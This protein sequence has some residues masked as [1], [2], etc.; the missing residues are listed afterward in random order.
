M[1]V[2]SLGFPPI[3]APDAR[4]LVLGSLPGQVS[5]A[6]REYYA[7]P[8]NAFWR[9]MGA[10]FEAGPDLEYRQRSARLIAAG[11]AVWDVCAA[12]VRAGSLDAAIEPDTVVANDFAGFF[13]THRGI[14][15]VFANGGTAH[16][17]YRRL[18][19]P[20]LSQDLRGLP[21][22]LLPSTSPAHASLRFEQKL[23]RWRS[24]RDRLAQRPPS[25]GR[26]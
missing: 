22:H 8:H 1:P 23:E 12:A 16:R 19:L 5:L 2:P 24:V 20:T 26:A 7:Q 11:V 13:A 15:H 3:A 6:R 14:A 10:L 25:A 17:L 4:V 9:I 18:V 21:L